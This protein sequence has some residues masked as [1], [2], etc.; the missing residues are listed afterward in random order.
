MMSATFPEC[1]MD[2]SREDALLRQQKHSF[3]EET[4]F[5]IFLLGVMFDDTLLYSFGRLLFL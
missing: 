1:D 4:L 5:V 3:I 2:F